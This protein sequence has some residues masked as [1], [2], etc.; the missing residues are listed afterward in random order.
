MADLFRDLVDELMLGLLPPFKLLIG[1]RSRSLNMFVLFLGWIT[2]TDD[3]KPSSLPFRRFLVISLDKSLILFSAV[4][5][6]SG[7]RLVARDDVVPLPRLEVEDLASLTREGRELL[8][9][10]LLADLPLD[11]RSNTLEFPPLPPLPPLAPTL[12]SFDFDNLS[13]REFLRVT[14]FFRSF[15]ECPGLI[16]PELCSSACSTLII[17]TDVT[18]LPSTSSES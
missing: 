16:L 17:G 8:R 12:G 11:R 18:Y 5:G 6:L 9:F 14:G 3:D 1:L 4:R 13:I 7:G 10:V 2:D 15:S